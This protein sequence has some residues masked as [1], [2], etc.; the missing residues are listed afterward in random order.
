MSLL[1]LW[2]YFSIFEFDEWYFILLHVINLKY[3]NLQYILKRTNIWRIFFFIW[4]P[5]RWKFNWWKNH[6]FLFISKFKLIDFTSNKELNYYKKIRNDKVNNIWFKMTIFAS[7]IAVQN[8]ETKQVIIVQRDYEIS[9]VSF[10]V[11]N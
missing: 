1:T 6:F 11:R 7:M 3:K 10:V 4:P 2:K 9:S 8:P 5:W